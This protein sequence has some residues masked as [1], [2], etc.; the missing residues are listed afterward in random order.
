MNLV[1]RSNFGRIGRD[2]DRRPCEPILVVDYDRV[3]YCD[4]SR[5]DHGEARQS[6]HV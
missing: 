6:S 2:V 1:I 5:Y 3:L 4:F